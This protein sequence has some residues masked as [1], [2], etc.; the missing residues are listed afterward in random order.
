MAEAFPPWVYIQE[1]LREREWTYLD[2]AKH[3]QLSPQLAWRIVVGSTTISK[4]SAR[5][6]ARAF[7]TSSAFW[8]NLQQTWKDYL[9]THDQATA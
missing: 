3:S 2:L 5:E 1:E 7:G 6:L 4:R 8:L 9:T